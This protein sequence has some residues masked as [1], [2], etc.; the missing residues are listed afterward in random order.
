[1]TQSPQTRTV[2]KH[3]QIFTTVST[4]EKKKHLIQKFGI[5]EANIFQSRDSSFL[6]AIMEATNG[7]GVDVVLNSLVGD[8]LHASWEC[9]AAFG[10]FV[11]IGKRDILDA[12]RLGME[13]FQ[14]SV[15]FTAFDLS[16][17]FFHEDPLLHQKWTLLH[18]EVLTLFRTGKSTSIDPLEV[19]DVADVAKALRWFSSRNRMGK[20]AINFEKNE[21]LISVRPH[22]YQTTFRPQ[23]AYI[24][25]GCLGGIGRSMSKWMLS[26]GARRFI[27]L[28]LSGAEKPAAQR[29][30]KDLN[31]SGAECLVIKGDVCNITD[32]SAVVDAAG[33]RIGGVVQAAMGLSVSLYLIK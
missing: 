21:S 1:M 22:T 2:S 25:I 20:I 31:Q 16:D 10:R 24:M 23:K 8:L 5:K 27:F 7:R 4:N 13:Q 32:V 3:M 14:K 19:F 26:R 15:T 28:G 9:C 30:I 17:F 29:L 33:E 12:G 6:P 18:A 11:E